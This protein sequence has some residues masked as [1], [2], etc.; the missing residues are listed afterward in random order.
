MLEAEK[1][2]TSKPPITED[3]NTSKTEF[4]SSVIERHF[5]VIKTILP[6]ISS[7]FQC[8]TRPT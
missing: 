4:Y 8:T 2:Q 7:L 1:E 5:E 6:R 3:W